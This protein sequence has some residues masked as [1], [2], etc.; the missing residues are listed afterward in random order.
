VDDA[1]VRGAL[2]ER[3]G[4]E[5][6]PGIGDLRGKI[7]RVGLMGQTAK[8]ELVLL[9]LNAFEAALSQNGFRC[10]GGAGVAAAEKEFQVTAK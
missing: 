8:P 5:I 9:L 1:K 2:T 6:G 4:I 10:Q 7:W 3:F